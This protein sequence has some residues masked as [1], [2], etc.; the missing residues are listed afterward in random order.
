MRTESGGCLQGGC[1]IKLQA[2]GTPAR[3]NIIQVITAPDG[4]GAERL[5]RELNRQLPAYGVDSRAVF[6]TNPN[7]IALSRREICLGLRSPRSPIAPIKLHRYIGNLAHARLS[8]IHAH[9]T[10]P[11]YYTAMGLAGG[12]RRLLYTEHNTHNRRRN[13]P[14]MR[15]MEQKI[16]RRYDAIIC[17]SEGTK[18][19]LERWLA[20]EAVCRRLRVIY[21]GSRLFSYKA[22]RQFTPGN[23]RVV[24]IG[25]LT[26][27]KGFDTAIEAI[28]QIRSIV[29]EYQI[30][31]AG[32]EKHLLQKLVHEKG[33]NDIVR[34]A[35]WSEN[36]ESYLHNAHVQLIPSRWEGFGL[37]VVEGL[38]TGL[39]IVA[40]D[41]P[42]L[43]EVLK[44]T[45]SARLVRPGAASAL[46]EELKNIH[47]GFVNGVDYAEEARKRSEQYSMDRMIAAYA[48]LYRRILK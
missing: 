12:I 40:F 30:V 6:L 32:P 46:S 23:L 26:R 9:L 43:H 14:M 8:A 22:H 41:V 15:R 34:F 24:S 37:V 16:Y 44:N 5:V 29:S 36:V 39:P 25:S 38:S 3:P 21:N 10:H 11:L 4:G 42:G 17:I 19:S 47:H 2:H 35:G 33:L 18:T 20:D 48:R 45:P 1:T 7:K 13:I 31:G 27:K 28:A